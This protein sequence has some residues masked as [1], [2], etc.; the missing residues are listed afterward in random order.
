M[1]RHN[2]DMRIGNRMRAGT[3]FIDERAWK[4]QVHDNGVISEKNIVSREGFRDYQATFADAISHGVIIG[5]GQ[6]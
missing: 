6:L 3:L 4:F 5:E 1:S 2:A